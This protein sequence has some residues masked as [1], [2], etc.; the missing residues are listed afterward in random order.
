MDT[1]FT[2]MGWIIIFGSVFGLGAWFVR[3]VDW[4][5]EQRRDARHEPMFWSNFRP[6]HPSVKISRPPQRTP[7]PP[8]FEGEA[9][10]ERQ[11][12]EIVQEAKDGH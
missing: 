1:V 12:A 6:A 3:M 4:R 2:I 7:P 11:I 8:P 9:D 5:S 10:I